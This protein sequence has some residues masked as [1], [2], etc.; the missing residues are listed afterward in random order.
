MTEDA[1]TCALMRLLP[2][3]RLGIRA[4]SNL[5]QLEIDALLL[6]LAFDFADCAVPPPPSAFG[7]AAIATIENVSPACATRSRDGVNLKSGVST[8]S[9]RMLPPGYIHLGVAKE[10]VPSLEDF[11]IAPDR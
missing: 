6:D 3:F 2:L 4:G 11:G 8:G 7:E 10:I 1:G 5:T 9:G